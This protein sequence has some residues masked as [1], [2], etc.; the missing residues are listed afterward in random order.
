MMLRRDCIDAM[1][2]QMAGSDASESWKSWTSTGVRL[3]LSDLARIVEI[4]T[5]WQRRNTQRT[6][7]RDIDVHLLRD[8][9]LSRAQILRE[10]NKPF[11]RA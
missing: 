4:F 7:L 8:C 1:P 5:A 2:V 9:G 10:I 3:L 11:W 6:A